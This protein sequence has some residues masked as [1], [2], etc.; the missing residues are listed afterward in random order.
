MLYRF[1]DDPDRNINAFVRPMFIPL[2]DRDLVSFSIN[3]GL[4]MREPSFGR[5]DDT[6]GVGM[7]FT[8]V[9]N[10]AS[11]LDAATACYNP[12]I[13]SP[14]RSNETFV[15][16]TCQYEVTPWW[17]I[18]PDVQY[19]FNPGGGVVNP[20]NPTRKIKNETVIGARTNV[21]F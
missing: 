6:A 5:D 17:R 7:G 2:Q 15:E 8:R 19:V 3:A 13:Y 11:G 16:A 1:A 4:T 12:G 14:V 18:Q 21:A 20:N 9:S 10:A